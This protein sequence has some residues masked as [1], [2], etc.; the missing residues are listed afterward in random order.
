H[1]DLVRCGIAIYGCDP[2]GSDPREQE[3]EPAL[4]LSSYVAALKPAHAGETVGYGRRFTAT[5]DTW[6][7]TVPIGYGDGLTRAL[8]GDGGVLIGD[9]RYPM[10][11]TMS[12]D[13]LTVEVGAPDAVEVGDRVILI[14]AEGTGRLTVEALARRIGTINYEVVCSISPRVP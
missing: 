13:N 2:F 1:F 8:S 12:M 7:A 14:G 9:R 10:V 5:G 3:L 4:E 6:I 11:G